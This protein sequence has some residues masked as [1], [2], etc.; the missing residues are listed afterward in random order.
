MED[1]QHLH[2][3]NA[4]KERDNLGAMESV[5]GIITNAKKGQVW[6]KTINKYTNFVKVGL[7]EMAQRQGSVL[8]IAILFTSSVYSIIKHSN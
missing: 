5:F 6:N 8:S 4:H 7:L 1:T 3:K 2:V